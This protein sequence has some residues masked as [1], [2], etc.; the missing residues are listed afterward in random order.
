MAGFTKAVYQIIIKV[1]YT[2][3]INVSL[4]NIIDK[5]LVYGQSVSKSERYD[6]VFKGSIIGSE[7]CFSFVTFLNS[8]KVIG[9]MEVE[10]SI[11]LGILKPVQV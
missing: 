7:A 11:N 9:V 6:K 2:E 1:S 4:K 3:L 8:E 5:T 10:F